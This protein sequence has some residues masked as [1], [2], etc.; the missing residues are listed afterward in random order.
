MICFSGSSSK[1]KAII[2]G[3]VVGGASL[4]LLVITALLVWFKLSTRQ[5]GT[6][7]GNIK[8]LLQALLL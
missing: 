5:R 8:T 1:K 3:G 2:I 4:L 7:R 6:L